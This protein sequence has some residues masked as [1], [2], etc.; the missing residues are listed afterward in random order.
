MSKW[1][2]KQETTYRGSGHDAYAVPG[3]T[4]FF[5]PADPEKGFYE[6]RA[7]T[8]EEVIEV[9]EQIDELTDVLRVVWK[10]TID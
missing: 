2:V 1:K 3:D 5:S 8:L 4:T 6:D 9:L 10:N 7:L